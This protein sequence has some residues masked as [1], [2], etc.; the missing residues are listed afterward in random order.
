MS[1]SSIVSSSS[2]NS[3]EDKCR[4]SVVSES[5]TSISSVSISSASYA[6]LRDFSDMG[7][8]EI[9]GPGGTIRGV[10]NRVRAGLANFENPVPKVSVDGQG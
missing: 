5:L 1:S 4:E 7:E 6:G 10:R 9:L 8:K 3:D 2:I